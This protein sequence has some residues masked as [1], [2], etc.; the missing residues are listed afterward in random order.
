LAAAAAVVTPAAASS[1]GATG[2]GAWAANETGNSGCCGSCGRVV[3]RVGREEAHV[4]PVAH[5]ARDVGTLL[6]DRHAEAGVPAAD[7]R[8][9]ADRAGANDEHMR[10]LVGHSFDRVV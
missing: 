5:G 7:R 2:A 10:A 3:E 8:L 1:S 6:G 4:L 9:E